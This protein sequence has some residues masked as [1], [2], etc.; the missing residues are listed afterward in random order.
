MRYPTA[1]L[2]LATALGCGLLAAPAHADE[3]AASISEKPPPPPPSPAR[4]ALA[5]GAAI[6]PG[7]VLHGAGHAALGKW[8]IAWP[9]LGVEMLGLGLGAAGAF[10]FWYSGAARDLVGPATALTLVG[11]GL[12]GFSWLADVYGVLAPPGGTGAPDRILP[13]VEVALGYRYVHDPRFSY[14][15]LAGAALDL[16]LRP[17]RLSASAWGALDAGNQRLRA[18]VAY[19][20]LGPQPFKDKT[21]PAEDGSFVEVSLGVTHHAYQNEGFGLTLAEGFA[22]GRLDLARLGP[23]LE[24]SFAEMGLG[25]ALGGYDYAHAPGEAASLLL[26][27]AAIGIYLGSPGDPHGEVSLFYD[28]RHDDYAA[29]LMMPGIV[30]G[31]LGHFGLGGTFYMT[32]RLGF[33]LEAQIGSAVVAGFSLR[34]RGG[35][36]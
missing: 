23:T 27:R 14:R 9:I 26:M 36:R 19:R 35:M 29:G 7:L 16:R 34:Y 15:N 1:F 10:T 6:V 4:R 3:P 24:G 5:T 22:F 32:E 28:H 12:L 18:S 30:S 25:W 2:V 21:A 20:F 31:V 11:G 13:H 8:Q 17:V 33:G